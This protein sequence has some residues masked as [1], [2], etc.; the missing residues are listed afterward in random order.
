M[1]NCA[2]V[3]YE[4]KEEEEEVLLVKN[5]AK[6]DSDENN[7]EYC[8][9]YRPILE[10]GASEGAC[11]MQQSRGSHRG[12]PERGRKKRRRSNV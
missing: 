7:C 10:S 6:W 5:P 1:Q 11:C 9:E 8:A 4:E 2:Q 3:D 12:R